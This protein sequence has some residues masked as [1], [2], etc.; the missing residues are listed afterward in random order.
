MLQLV[1]FSLLA[2]IVWFAPAHGANTLDGVRGRG[3]LRCGVSFASAGLGAPDSAGKLQGFDIDYCRAIAAAVLNDPDKVT[4]V[5]ATSLVARFPLLQSGDIDVLIR[6]VTV[7]FGRDTQL[8]LMFGPTVIYD[9]QGI[10]VPRSLSAK[11]MADLGGATICVFP[12][13]NAEQNIVG[14]FQRQRIAYKLLSIDNGDALKRAFFSGRCDVFTSDTLTLAATRAAAERPD[15]YEILPGM[16]APSPLAPM[17]RQGDDQ[18]LNI[19]KW[20]VYATFI[21]EAHAVTAINAEQMAQVT[22]DDE[23]KRLLGT[24]PGLSKELGLDDLW[25]RRVIRA[26][27]NYG[28]IFERNLGRGSPLKLER[29]LNRQWTT[30]GLIYAPPFQ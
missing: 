30:G 28:E 5:N 27:G 9:G 22:T 10:M 7:L 20:V 8:G 12:G 13:S 16:I 3:S 24:V 29:G 14:H 21:A 19:V 26:V 17:V 15:D 11:T 18:W 1:S 6:G 25:A 23:I 4:F 2:V